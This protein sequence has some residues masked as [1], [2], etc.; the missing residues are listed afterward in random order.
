HFAIRL[1]CARTAG[2]IT[3][4]R[5]RPMVVAVA[6][7]VVAM[8]GGCAHHEPRGEESI[9]QWSANHPQASEEL[10]RWV[11]TH[12]QAAAR[13]FEWDAQHPQRAHEFVT[14]AN[15]HPNL[16]IDGFV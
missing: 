6:A 15:Y 7:T 1:T 2:S 14:W 16:Q 3:G 4:G 11:Q 13:F 10:G 8:V 9:E 5:M 12:P